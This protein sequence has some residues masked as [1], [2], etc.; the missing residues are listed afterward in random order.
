MNPVLNT[1]TSLK[2]TLRGAIES[3]R[4]NGVFVLSGLNLEKM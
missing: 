2:G 3:V 1:D 4:V